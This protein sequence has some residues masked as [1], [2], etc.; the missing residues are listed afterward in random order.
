M[1][2]SPF[3]S[4]MAL[5]MMASEAF[6]RLEPTD[7]VSAAFEAFRAKLWA[8]IELSNDPNPYMQA[9]NLINRYAQS[10]LVDFSRGDIEAL[11][12]LKERVKFSIEL[13]P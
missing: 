7:D 10:S 12:K 8:M 11:D 4:P 6:S 13:M 1:R 3:D 9:W 2:G 5:L